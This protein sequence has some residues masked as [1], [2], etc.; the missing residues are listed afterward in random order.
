MRR[1]SYQKIVSLFFCCAIVLTHTSGL[2]AHDFKYS[3]NKQANDNFQLG[4]SYNNSSRYVKAI[5]YLEKAL[6]QDAKF[7]AAF[8]EAAFAFQHLNNKDKAIVYYEQGLILDE[9]FAPAYPQLALLYIEKGEI[10]KSYQCLH[11]GQAIFPGNAHINTMMATLQKQ[12]GTM[13]E[14]KSIAQQ[15]NQNIVVGQAGKGV[16]AGPRYYEKGAIPISAVEQTLFDQY[17]RK[18]EHVQSSDLDEESE[19]KQL[20][21]WYAEIFKKYN[22]NAQNF[23]YML[24]KIGY[25]EIPPESYI[26]PKRSGVE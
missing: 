23:N 13:L 9:K 5:H 11:K 10:F 2:Y 1:N 4:L 12:Y 21:Q 26:A 16:F 19:H 15:N 14:L 17:T 22:I 18:V 8:F 20:L 6:E 3:R 25:G 7:A 24:K